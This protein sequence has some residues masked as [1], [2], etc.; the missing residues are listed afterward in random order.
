MEKSIARDER[1][2]RERLTPQQFHVLRERGTEP[3]FSGRYVDEKGDGTYCCAACGAELFRSATKY[4]SGTGWPS[5]WEPVPGAHIEEEEDRSFWM[6]RTEVSCGRC[7]AHLGHVFPDGPPPTGQRY[8]INS[9]AL[10][11]EEET[12]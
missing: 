10:D 9:A 8:C 11:L 5:F 4:D 3:P 12:G 7:D 6:V 2:W 1:E